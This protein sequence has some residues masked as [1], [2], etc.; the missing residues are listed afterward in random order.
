MWQNYGMIA[1]PAPNLLPTGGTGSYHDN[2]GRDAGTTGKNGLFLFTR[3]VIGLRKAHPC[4][5][6]DRF[7]DFQMDSGKDVTYWFKGRDGE[8]DVQDGDGRIHWRVD[9]SAIGD[10]DFLLLVNLHHE[11]A[12]FAVPA[13]RAGKQW[14]RIIDTDGWAESQGNFWRRQSAEAVSGGYFVHPR[15]L[16]VLQ[17]TV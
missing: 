15:S 8:S 12:D 14:R 10:T 4:L 7:A 13:P 17:E 1:T 3:F 6:L 16:V 5:R 2:Y 11:G 9:G